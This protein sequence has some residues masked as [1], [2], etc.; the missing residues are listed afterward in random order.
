MGTFHSIKVPT[1]EPLHT[2]FG[3]TRDIIRR[4]GRHC[5][6][7]TKIAVVILNQ[8]IRPFTAKWHKISRL[9][10]FKDAA[11]CQ[12]FRKELAGVQEQLKKY[13]RML[14]DVAGVEDITSLEDV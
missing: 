5:I 8:V 2:L 14:V 6:E 9:D 12:I 3:L 7:F 10:A 13:A 11:Q 4:N 1:L